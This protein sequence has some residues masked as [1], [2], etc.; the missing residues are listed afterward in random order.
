[1]L[2]INSLNKHEDTST[3]IGCVFITTAEFIYKNREMR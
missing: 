1:M 3:S 2:I